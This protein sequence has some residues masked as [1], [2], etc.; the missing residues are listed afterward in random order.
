MVPEKQGLK[1]CGLK[2]VAGLTPGLSSGSRKTRI[3]TP[4][5]SEKLSGVGGRHQ[6]MLARK[7]V[8][9]GLSD[10][11]C[12]SED[13]GFFYL[14]KFSKK[15]FPE[16]ATISAVL[17]SFLKE[18]SDLQDEF[19]KLMDQALIADTLSAITK[20]TSNERD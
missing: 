9:S 12:H 16:T 13:N 19:T 17:E 5:V 11:I 7:I 6:P 4:V 18:E 20:E 2:I 8:K 14:T 15:K 1:H 3:E 10:L